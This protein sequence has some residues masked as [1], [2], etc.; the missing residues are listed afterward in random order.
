MNLYRRIFYPNDSVTNR[1]TDW[2][3]RWIWGPFHGWW[4][5]ERVDKERPFDSYSQW[6]TYDGTPPPSEDDGDGDS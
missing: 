4:K 2:I 1:L 5:Y 6:W 3:I